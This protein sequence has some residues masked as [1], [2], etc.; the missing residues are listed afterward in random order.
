MKRRI[1]VTL[2]L[3]VAV[4]QSG[5]AQPIQQK[6]PEPAAVLTGADQMVEVVAALK[7]K[8]VGLVVNHTSVTGKKH[9]A[10]TLLAS[11]VKVV[12]VL[13]PEHGFRGNAEAGDIIKDGVDQKTGLPVVSLYGK[14]KKPTPAHLA[15]I[16]LVVFDIQD[17]GARFYTYIS[18]LH[19]VME[20]CAEQ[21]KK[22]IILDRPNPNG[23]YVDGPVLRSSLKSFV[24]MHNIPI[25]H[26]NT[27]GE[28]AMMING[29]G[30]LAGGVKCDLEII[31]MKNWNHQTKYAIPIKPSPNLANDHAIALYPSICLFE[32]TAISLGRGTMM[33][34]EIL[35][36]PELTSFPFQFTPVDI[37]GM[38]TNP[39]HEN[40]LCYGLDLRKENVKDQIDLSY[41]IKFYKA[42]P[43]KEKFFIPFFDKLAG[44]EELKNQIKSG[45]TEETI[46]ATWKNE[47]DAYR[48]IRAKYLLYPEVK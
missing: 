19:Y 17:V 11:G 48:K 18:T 15:D 39:P 47:L 32:G 40:K 5:C 37:E 34:F 6:K 26:G 20:A 25:V 30:W 14:D 12:K 2:V 45:M 24:G 1:T 33:P 3:M 28:M 31:K 46:R 27:I 42:Y 35:G 22:L 8:S 4:L 9:L 13:A 23:H 7:G 43:D 36:S 38:A 44:N 21:G 41:L 10:D 29:E 16:D